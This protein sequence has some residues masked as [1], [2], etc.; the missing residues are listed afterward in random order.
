MLTDPMVSVPQSEPEQYLQA[1]ADLEAREDGSPSPGRRKGLELAW[2]GFIAQPIMPP[3]TK[4]PKTQRWAL[5]CELT[6]RALLSC[7]NFRKKPSKLR[8]KGIASL[9]CDSALSLEK[10]PY[11]LSPSFY[12]RW[13]QSW[14]Q[15]PRK[16]LYVG[17]GLMGML[18]C[19]GGATLLVTKAGLT[20]QRWTPVPNPGTFKSPRK[21]EIGRR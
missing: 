10:A 3:R 7:W 16:Q 2:Q 12:Q 20:G 18:D 19:K 9:F 8:K 21:E 13:G 5:G 14:N 17:A 4:R 6:S 1:C 15:V 11:L